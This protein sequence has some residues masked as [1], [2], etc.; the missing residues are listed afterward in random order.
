MA[1]RTQGTV[2]R[3]ETA[4]AA[5]VTI[6]NI[7][8]ANPPVVTTSSSHGYANGAIV[9]IA[10]VGGMLQVNDRAFVVAAQTSTTFAL[11]GVNGTGFTAYTSG[12]TAALL[13][14]TPVAE[15]TSLTVGG[16]GSQQLDAT[17]L[18]SEVVEQVAGLPNLGTLSM[19]I[20][21]N[22]ADTGQAAMRDLA[23]A[24][25]YRAITVTTKTGFVLCATGNTSNYNAQ[26]GLNDIQRGSFEFTVARRPAWFA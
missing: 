19:E 4:R 14:M 5:T 16:S 8:A 25:V 9:Y 22:H 6:T 23:E 11:R 18:L 21:L 13:T 10:S 12:G 24:T 1:E 20:T 3:V 2:L 17:N 26:F 15:V 7:T